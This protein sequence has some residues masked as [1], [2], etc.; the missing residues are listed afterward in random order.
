MWAPVL[1]HG[2]VVIGLLGGDFDGVGGVFHLFC[3]LLSMQDN[4][5]TLSARLR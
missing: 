3:S 1:F 2:N 5:R 4:V